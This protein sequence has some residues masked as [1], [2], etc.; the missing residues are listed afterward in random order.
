E[1]LKVGEGENIKLL[2]ATESN[3]PLVRETARYLQQQFGNFDQ[4][5]KSQQLDYLLKGERQ[6]VQVLPLNDGRGIDWLIVVVMPEADFMAE[7]NAN[8]RITI[9]LCLL[10]FVV[11]IAVAI[12]TAQWISRPI[13]LITK[14]SEE[15][16]AGNFNSQVA[17]SQI[18]ELENLANSFKNMAAQLNNSFAKLNSVIEQAN[19]VSIQV[20]TSTSQIADAGKQLE[21]TALHQAISTNEVNA[22]AQAIAN[23]S[24]QLVKTIENVT[25]QA[26]ATAS[27]TSSSQK[28]LTEMAAV[29]SQLATA[30][31]KISSWLKITNEKA[32]NITTVVNR[33]AAVA[34][35]TNLISLNAAIEAEK[36]GESGVGFAVVA[37]EVRRLADNSS[38]ASQEIEDMVQDIQ[39]SVSKGVMEMDKFSQQVRHHVELVSRIAEQIAEVIE[40]VQS[41]TP[42]FEQ[43]SQSMEGQFEGAQQ[44]SLTISQL[45]QASQQTV[46]SLQNTNQALNQLND[47]AQ[48]LQS[49]VKTNE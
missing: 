6:F 4:I 31:N 18:V 37:R 25:Q 10:A 38:T 3:K 11:A 35:Q 28:N 15:M 48:E 13:L 42:Q 20:A 23:S 33:I 2:A 7:I 17:S 47:T 29:M 30:T 21:A 19:R 1:P 5:Q 43:V 41:L 8:T 16:A 34:D 36:A 26:I 46:A 40:Q 45:S 44:I 14:A 32:N 27:A 49:V 22:T 24:G 39:L 12:F 9:I